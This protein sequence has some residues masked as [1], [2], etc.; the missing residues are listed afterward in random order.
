MS[1]IRRAVLA[2]VVLAVGVLAACGGGG[3]EPQ[4]DPKTPQGVLEGAA[5]DKLDDDVISIDVRESSHKGE[6]MVDVTFEA[7][8]QMSTHLLKRSIERKMLDVYEALFTSA[9]PVLRAS[10]EAHAMTTDSEGNQSLNIVY[11]TSMDSDVASRMNWKNKYL[12]DPSLVWD[13]YF[14]NVNFQ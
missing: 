8:E 12:I 5:L 3:P 9:P 7:G 11:G 10:V 13:T 2:V 4:Y 1:S 14:K 6:W